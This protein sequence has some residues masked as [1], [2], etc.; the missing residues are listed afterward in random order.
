MPREKPTTQTK[1]H[2]GRSQRMMGPASYR[3]RVPQTHRGQSRDDR[4]RQTVT[5]TRAFFSVLSIIFH[6][7]QLP[8]QFPRFRKEAPTSSNATH[9]GMKAVSRPGPIAQH[10][11]GLLLRLVACLPMPRQKEGAF[12]QRNSHTDPL[13]RAHFSCFPAPP[14]S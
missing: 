2:A 4:K 10:R 5:E 1:G 12:G 9:H 7:T 8:K 6:Y 13:K 3:R 11:Q 14:S